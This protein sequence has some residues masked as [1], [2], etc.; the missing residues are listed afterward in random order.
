MTISTFES[1]VE[2]Y[3]PESD[4]G[5]SPDIVI[6]RADLRNGSY[7]L[8]GRER[9]DGGSIT[10][11]N[12]GGAYTADADGDRLPA[13]ERI[14]SG[15]AVQVYASL[16]GDEPVMG[17]GIVGEGGTGGKHHLFTGMV[18]DVEYTSRG[19]NTSTMTLVVDSYV[20]GVLSFRTVTDRFNDVPAAGTAD[21]ILDTLIREYA[22]EVDTRFDSF[23]ETLSYT[24]DGENLFDIVR[25]IVARIDAEAYA[26]RNTLVVHNQSSVGL[27]SEVS[28]SDFGDISVRES[29]IGLANAIRVNGAESEAVDDTNPDT[30]DT[31]SEPYQDGTTAFSPTNYATVTQSSRQTFRVSTR[32]ARL[33]SV[34]L[35][36]R[37]NGASEE[38]ITLRVQIDDG[39]GTAP[40]A[41]NDA[42]SDIVNTDRD[43]TDETAG[44]TDDGWTRFNFGDHTLPEPDPWVIV[45]TDGDTGQDIGLEGGGGSEPAMVARYQFNLAV[46][47]SDSDSR[48]RHRRRDQTLTRANISTL[49]EAQE[50]GN[51]AIDERAVPQSTVQAPVNS[52]D[53]FHL[54]VNDAVDTTWAA[55]EAAPAEVVVREKNIDFDGSVLRT[56]VTMEER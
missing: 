32:K 15:D 6:P 12:D 35:W 52:L 21:S 1:Y 45:E 36:T 53:G 3:R 30:L 42:S 24:A 38:N 50:L 11:H 4:I 23:P 56:T 55:E 18:R 13:S 19:P 14:M 47:Q 33:A 28:A 5:G 40:I 44:I 20:G 22:P 37:I 54:S 39:T 10:V 43:P 46:R 27:N 9:K 26:H 25:A 48:A 8:R 17:D 49:E 7:S 34:E 41:V 2:V 31:T 29:D 51:Q 16:Q